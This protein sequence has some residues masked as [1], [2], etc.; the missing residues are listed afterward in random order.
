M[1]DSDGVMFDQES[2]E[3][4]ARVVKRVEADPRGVVGRPATRSTLVP[5][6]AV[7]RCTSTTP[8][9]ARY[10][11]KIVDAD[12]NVNP[13]VYT[14]LADCWLMF[15]DGAVPT[16]G[17]SA[18]YTGR[19]SGVRASDGRPIFVLTGARG[20]SVGTM[21]VV[22]ESDGSILEPRITVS[23]VDTLSFD[24]ERAE[25]GSGAEHTGPFYVEDLGG[26]EALVSLH[27]ADGSHVGTVSL[28]DQ[29]LGDGVK[30][31]IGGSSTQRALASGVEADFLRD[32]LTTNL[33]EYYPDGVL[34]LGSN[35][36]AGNDPYGPS[37][38][39]WVD[40]S[41]VYLDWYG[42]GTTP[43]QIGS[44]ILCRLKISSTGLDLL[45]GSYRFGGTPIPSGTVTSV[46]ITAPAAGITASGGPITSSG[47]ITL[48][49]ANDLAALEALSGTNTI[50]YRSG[51]DT[52]SAVTIGSGLTFSS[53]TLSAGGSFEDLTA[54][55][56]VSLGNAYTDTIGF[57][58][59]AGVQQPT[60]VN[61]VS[62]TAGGSYGTTEQTLINDLVTA[63]NAILAR[64]REPGL[65]AT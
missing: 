21:D 1:A 36:T 58:G 57:W 15:P 20:S 3:R 5:E 9:E 8:T 37:F 62:G 41:A 42:V 7:V 31:T 35:N 33:L 46:N 38:M 52:W 53:G 22:R 12:V 16:A 63:V 18:R 25:G 11:G 65:I 60:A 51:A 28:E 6:V 24:S 29:V 50:Y 34:L 30:H 64:L 47:S 23:N 56:N 43:S 14:D 10:P 39:A 19:R 27:E 59:T 44:N 45:N 54:N 55:G 32:M 40:S 13:A 4:I 61:D 2:A 17:A 48:A 49:L 26:G